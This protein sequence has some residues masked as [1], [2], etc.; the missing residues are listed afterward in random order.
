MKILDCSFRDGGYRTN[1]H[2][3]KERLNSAVHL[4]NYY[5]VENCEIGFAIPNRG[6]D[7]GP[8][9]NI[10]GSMIRNLKEEVDSS[11]SLG[12]M[13]ETK[14]HTFFG[15]IESYGEWLLGGGREK[16][17]FVRI[18]ANVDELE[19][20]KFLAEL[21]DKAGLQV[22]VNIMRISELKTEQIND[23][24]NTGINPQNRYVLAD[25]FGKMTPQKTRLLFESLSS[26]H[27][28]LE[29]GFHGHNNRGFALANS[30][31]ASASGSQW[32]DGTLAG[33]GRGSGNTKT[34]EL[35]LSSTKHRKKIIESPWLMGHHLEEFE[36][37]RGDY[38]REDSFA[39]HFGSERGFHPN[40]VME[41]V[42]Q[43]STL[44]LGD[45][46]ELL[47]EG[48]EANPKNSDKD[49]EKNFTNVSDSNFPN[50]SGKRIVLLGRSSNRNTALAA[51]TASNANLRERLFLMNEPI[52]H[53]DVQTTVFVSRKYM[54]PGAVAK[55]DANS[56]ICSPNELT[57]MIEKSGDLRKMP[58]T[59][60]QVLLEETHTNGPGVLEFAI[61]TLVKYRPEAII[62]G[63]VGHDAK[64]EELEALKREFEHMQEIAEL[65]G[66][67]I[68]SLDSPNLGLPIEN[69]I[70]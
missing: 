20:T 7:D 4:L 64:P 17:D 32:V 42:G 2:F 46:L 1:W 16:F 11:L 70:W 60:R 35:I 43:S 8:F 44:D 62:I 33:H 27:P 54:V 69:G 47:A 61:R 10:S 48:P 29:L 9:I 12:F 67:K 39:F 40:V 49:L 41:L 52:S 45:V 14:R 68:T 24:I 6:F 18:A 59:D 30:L 50:I 55:L 65:N 38:S 22:F 19:E 37:D 13:A 57:K 25:S 15:S 23:A 31:E 5:Q 56:K 63:S 51:L 21:F 53:S 34:E 66:V 26:S 3:S 36:Y 58:L 28:G